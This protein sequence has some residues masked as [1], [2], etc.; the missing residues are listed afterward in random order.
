MALKKKRLLEYSEVAATL[1]LTLDEVHWLVGTRRL[2]E[3]Q[4]CGK[5]RIDQR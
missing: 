1:S 4:I 5:K 2:H 3:I